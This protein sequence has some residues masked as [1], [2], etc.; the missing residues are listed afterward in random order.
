MITKNTEYK[1]SFENV[2]NDYE[3]SKDILENSKAK[4]WINLVDKYENSQ[5]ENIRAVA[6]MLDTSNEV[7]GKFKGEKAEYAIGGPT[8]E[9]FVASYNKIYD[10]KLSCEETT[11]NGYKIKI[12]DTNYNYSVG[13]LAKSEEINNLY[14]ITAEDR[15]AEAMWIASPGCIGVKNYNV[16]RGITVNGYIGNDGNSNKLF[17]IRPLICLKQD[18]FLYQNSKGLLILN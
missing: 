12:G 7:W 5:N 15:K 16:I 1:L 2:Y 6:Y 11:V 18:V 10:I 8:I 13:G 17:G 9:L 14:A 3:G 4:K